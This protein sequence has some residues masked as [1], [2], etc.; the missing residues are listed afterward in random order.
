[1]LDDKFAALEI[2]KNYPEYHAWH[3]RLLARPTVA[4][5]HNDK[6]KAIEEMTERMSQ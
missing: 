5:V 1:M 2:E 6:A 4:K 3:Q